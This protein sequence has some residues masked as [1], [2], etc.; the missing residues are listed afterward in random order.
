MRTLLI[1]AALT[2]AASAS[3]HACEGEGR[4]ASICKAPLFKQ[5]TSCIDNAIPQW[6]PKGPVLSQMNL[7]PKSSV[8]A[9]PLPHLSSEPRIRWHAAV[10]VAH[11]CDSSHDRFDNRAIADFHLGHGQALSAFHTD[12]AKENQR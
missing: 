4:L 8:L 3:A 2:I 9:V 7:P 11:G 1:A 6:D 10:A 5:Y 12:I